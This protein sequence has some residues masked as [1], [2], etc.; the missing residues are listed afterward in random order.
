MR[1]VC[2]VEH[3]HEAVKQISD[4]VVLF[5]VK[6]ST[7]NYRISVLLIEHSVSILFRMLLR[8]ICCF[9]CLQV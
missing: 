5:S 6:M 7:D 8:C 2:C 9:Q 1:Y 4:S 3:M